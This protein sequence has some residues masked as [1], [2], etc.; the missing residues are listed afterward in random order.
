MNPL[1]TLLLAKL[2]ALTY[3][4]ICPEPVWSTPFLNVRV[5]MNAS[6]WLGHHFPVSQSMIITLGR[7]P[8]NP[9]RI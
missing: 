9:Y 7:K 3:Y 5:V 6:T 4:W 8:D 1:L 2:P